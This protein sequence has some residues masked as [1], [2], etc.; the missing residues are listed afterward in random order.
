[1]RRFRLGTL[2]LLIAFAALCFVMPELGRGMSR[3]NVEPEFRY[4]ELQRL[5]MVLVGVTLFLAARRARGE[6]RRDGAGLG[7]SCTRV[8]P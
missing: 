2:L 1:M 8:E 7:A 3:L 5:L 4:A 6:S